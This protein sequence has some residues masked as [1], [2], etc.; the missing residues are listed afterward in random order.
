MKSSE[1]HRL[2]VRAGV[3]KITISGPDEQ[4]RG[5]SKGDNKLVC[6]AVEIKV[7]EKMGRAYGNIINDY[8]SAKLG[9]IFDTYISKKKP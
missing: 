9:K 5:R 4:S 6:L 7:D 3:D 8:S 2:T 1:K